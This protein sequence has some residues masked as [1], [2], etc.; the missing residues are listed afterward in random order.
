MTSGILTISLDFELHWGSFEKWPLNERR[1]YF[2]ETRKVIP[3]MLSLFRTFGVHATWATVGML[4]F[5]NRR[6]L[7]NTMPSIR[8]SYSKKTLSAY[9]FIANQGIGESEIDDPFH[10]AASLVAEISATPFQEVGS[11]SFSHFYCNEPGQTLQEF[12]VDLRTAQ[13]VAREKIGVSL[14]SF[15]FPRNQFNEEYLRVCFEEGF[16]I[17]RENPKDWFWSIGSTEHE[18]YWKR[19]NRGMDAYLP[20]GKKN[21]FQL[22]DLKNSNDLPICLPA[23]R[24]LRP[25]ATYESVFNLR[26]IRRVCNEM[27]SA[28]RDGEVYHLWWHPHNFGWYPNENLDGLKRILDHFSHCREKYGMCSLSMGEI[29]DQVTRQEVDTRGMKQGAR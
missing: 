11:H 5:E 15:V 29:A 4:F 20:I 18:S 7:M 1:K 25:Y 24:L 16:V 6:E 10:F 19:L 21:T 27:E 2:L 26:R 22:E 14:R 13:S 3:R 17:V 28:A 23:S 12:K 9:S 8:P